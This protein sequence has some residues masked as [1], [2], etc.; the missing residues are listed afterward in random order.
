[1][2]FTRRS[3]QEFFFQLTYALLGGIGACTLCVGAGFGSI[4]AF[5]GWQ[6]TLVALILA[7]V[8]GAAVG[9][10]LMAAGR[11]GPRTALPFGSFL[12]VTAVAATLVGGPLI[13]WYLSLY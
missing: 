10:G 11:A 8:L 13:D 6:M 4:G 1:M 3:A 7:F 9:A 5:L 2:L 12:A